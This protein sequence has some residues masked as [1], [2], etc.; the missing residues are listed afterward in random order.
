V[1]D[2]VGLRTAKA[3]LYY[4]VVGRAIADGYNKQSGR[5]APKLQAVCSQ[6]SSENVQKLSEDWKNVPFAIVQSDVAHAAWYAHPRQE[7]CPE[8][9]HPPVSESTELLVC[10][11]SNGRCARPALIT[12]LYVEAIHVLIRPHLNISGLQDLKDRRVWA[13]NLGSGAR[14]SAERILSAA[15]VKYCQ[16]TFAEKNPERSDEEISQSEAFD[17]LGK[18]KIDAMIFSGPVPTHPLE[19]A[20]D[21][22]PEIHFYSFPYE[23]VQKLTGDESYTEA[24]IRAEDYGKS[25]PTLTVGVEALLLTNDRAAPAQVLSLADYIHSN[26]SDL[27]AT[28]RDLLETQ[29]AKEHDDEIERLTQDPQTFLR[30][31]DRWHDFKSKSSIQAKVQKAA[32]TGSAGEKL[33]LTYDEK[34]ALKDYMEY[35]EAN[36]GVARLPLLD[37]PTPDAL[38]PDFYAGDPA[39]GR[40]FS[41]QR[42]TLWKRQLITVLTS[43]FLVLVSLFVWMRRKLHR[44]LVRH[45]D[46]VL[47]TIATFL[48]WALG[49]F[50]L[51]HYEAFVN[52]DFS[53]WWKSFGTI[54]L[55]FIPF[56]G[57]TA[58]TPNGQTTILVLKW[59]GVFLVGGF[60]SPLIRRLLAADVVAP[61]ISWLQGRPLMQKDIAGHIVII[62]WDERGREIVHRLM[63]IP[64]NADRG[65][66]VVT[67]GR[68]DFTDDD[69]MREV[70]SVVCDTTQLQC[71]EKAR[72]SF[73]RSVTILSAWKPSDPN[74]RRRSVDRDVADTKTIQLLRGIRDLCAAQE[75]P[76][77]PSVTAEI[78]SA[79][80]R[81]EAE[82]VGRDVIQLEVVCVDAL[83][84]DVLI[85]SVLNPGVA[86]LFAHLIGST[87]NGVPN[88]TEM[89][90]IQVPREFLGK[91]F[92]EM[93]GY[94]SSLSRSH[95]PP[96][97]PIGVCR[98]SQVFVNPSD[99]KVGRIQ[100]GD[101]LFV[102]TE[103]RTTGNSPAPLA[104]GASG[105]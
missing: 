64:G 55:Y 2:G 85:Q 70:I 56:V 87:G 101:M 95:C 23:L 75:P 74:D 51:Y 25:E 65:V 88:V 86:T 96:S 98:A 57:R 12:P 50:L 90:R 105:A 1:A 5:D 43:C 60:L 104:A 29:K 44:I 53:P 17:L 41:R 81:R 45:S 9:D 79:S 34:E 102:I 40:Y 47:A 7:K 31:L 68:V 26:G 38:V 71:L 82:H 18:M 97:I 89:S 37:L 3:K 10:S 28:L 72:I 14:F 39:I 15:G 61:F 66:V 16:V 11:P 69:L 67:P 93:L 30:R 78:R 21:K 19:D 22:F 20:L 100:E 32:T 62:N 84:D 77:H 91:S 27:R 24:L 73:A 83:G 8:R 35:E 36:D 58:L 80:N 6:G 99:E 63:A 59:L 33:Y 94:F 103:R 54:V 13:G 76:A 46:V 49:S 48:A 52:Q 4:A 92:A 42:S